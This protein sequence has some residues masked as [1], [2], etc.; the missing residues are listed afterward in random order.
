VAGATEWFDA[1][2]D[3]T[4]AKLLEE[5][6]VAWNESAERDPYSFLPQWLHAR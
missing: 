3:G 2:K 4:M 5:N 1:A 6:S